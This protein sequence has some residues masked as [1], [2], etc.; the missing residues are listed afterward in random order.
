MTL[1]DVAGCFHILVLALMR[2]EEGRE[3]SR[4]TDVSGARRPRATSGVCPGKPGQAGTWERTRCW[5][6]SITG[7]VIQGSAGGGQILGFLLCSPA[8]LCAPQA[9]TI[10]IP[11]F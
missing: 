2:A 9:P 3:L 8:W 4:G 7:L 10:A 11:T 6:R 1:L 5:P